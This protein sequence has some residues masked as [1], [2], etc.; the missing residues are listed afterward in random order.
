MLWQDAI[1]TA[2]SLDN[3]QPKV[4]SD[5]TGVLLYDSF[6]SYLQEH[7]ISFQLC[8][9]VA[10]MLPLSNKPEPRLILTSIEK[11]PAFI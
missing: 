1:Y 11:V 5:Q 3:G 8:L 10:D 6:T 9:T 4:I 2:L 7:G